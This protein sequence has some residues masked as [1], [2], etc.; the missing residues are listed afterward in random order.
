MVGMLSDFLSVVEN[1]IWYRYHNNPVFPFVN[2]QSLSFADIGGLF[3]K[4]PHPDT[5]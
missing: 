2:K 3:L 5:G 1:G 4:N